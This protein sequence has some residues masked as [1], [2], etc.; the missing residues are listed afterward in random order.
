MLRLVGRVSSSG[1]ARSATASISSVIPLNVL[2]SI[3]NPPSGSRAPRWMLESQPLRRPEP[4]STAST[5]RSR[6]CTGF[7]LTHADPRR[8]AAYGEAGSLTTTPSWPASSA[9]STNASAGPGVSRD[10]P[11]GAV[12]LRD[13]RVEGGEPLGHGPVEQVVAVEVEQVEE[14][15]RHVRRRRPSRCATRSP[16]TAAAGPASSSASASPS[17][18]SE[19]G[20][21]RPRHLDHLRQPGGDVLQRAG[22]DQHLV[23]PAVHL[24]PDPV[25]LGVDRHL[26]VGD[27]LGHALRDRRAPTRRA[28]AAPD[29]RPRAGTRPARPRRRRTRRRTTATVEPASIAARR[30]A[31]S[32]TPAAAASPPGPARRAHPAAPRRSPRRAARP[33]PPEVARPKSSATA[34]D[35]AAWEPAPASAAI[36]SNAACTSSTSSVGESAGSGRRLQP[37]PA[38]AG[39]PLPQPTAEVGRDDLAAR[40]REVRP[41]SSAIAAAFALRERVAATAA[42]VATRSASSMRPLWR[43]AR[44]ST[45]SHLRPAPLTRR[46]TRTRSRVGQVSSQVSPLRDA[47]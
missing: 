18:T 37:A 35:R 27:R 41:S 2:P 9:R 10:Q 34:V 25:E 8:P 14:V 45:V 30:T 42:E 20:R 19:V 38:Q 16:G 39:A 1:T 21:E 12:C 43:A 26:A 46:H 13:Q 29:G 15:R 23:V 17:S 33:A 11:G 44:G 31:V 36:A 5:T 28:S 3:T 7:T 4:H 6:V 22:R 47:T 32:G 40:R 24:D